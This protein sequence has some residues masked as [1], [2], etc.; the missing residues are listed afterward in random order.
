M[1]NAL[2]HLK[3]PKHSD[4]CGVGVYQLVT[5]LDADLTTG[6]CQTPKQA[7]YTEEQDLTMTML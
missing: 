3:A 6:K 5:W 7:L 1:Q 2:L 4:D